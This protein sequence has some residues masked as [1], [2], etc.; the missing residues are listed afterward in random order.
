MDFPH[1][2]TFVLKVG[3]LDLVDRCSL[4]LEVVLLC[5]LA[6][7][8]NDF[9]IF[10]FFHLGSNFSTTHLRQSAM[11]KQSSPNDYIRTKQVIT[12]SSIAL[13]MYIC[14]CSSYAL[15]HAIY[16]DGRCL[17]IWWHSFFWIGWKRERILCSTA[18]W[19]PSCRLSCSSSI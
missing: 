18:T 1:Y 6:Y 2:L 5:F 10:V 12:T 19:C 13:F 4:G 16:G 14:M 3:K 7:S 9:E 15:P 8:L 11:S 17:P